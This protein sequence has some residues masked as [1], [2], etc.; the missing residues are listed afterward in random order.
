MCGTYGASTQ[1][2][3]LNHWTKEHGD[4]RLLLYLDMSTFTIIGLKIIY[5]HVGS[6]SYVGCTRML[7]GD[8]VDKFQA[9][10]VEHWHTSHPT[11]DNSYHP[12]MC[13]VISQE[14]IPV[15]TDQVAADLIRKQG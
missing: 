13:Q 3:L 9:S 14:D 15:L 7:Y 10:I 11:M 1:K 8:T 4:V 6:C 12:R 2:L 5:N